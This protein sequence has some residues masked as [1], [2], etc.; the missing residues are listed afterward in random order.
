MACD[1]ARHNSAWLRSLRCPALLSRR[2]QSAMHGL[3]KESGYTHAYSGQCRCGATAHGVTAATTQPLVEPHLVRRVASGCKS[4]RLLMM[5]GCNCVRS[6]EGSGRMP[7]PLVLSLVLCLVLALLSSPPVFL[8]SLCSDALVVV[9]L[10][11]VLGGGRW[12]RPAFRAA[13]RCP[14]RRAAGGARWLLARCG[15]GAPRR[16]RH[17]ASLVVLLQPHPQHAQVDGRDADRH[18]RR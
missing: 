5:G 2:S 17:R 8:S 14:A 7:R 10:P 6:G 1:H 16:A 3:C 18:D 15:G 4:A 9:M 13:L 11:C 12:F